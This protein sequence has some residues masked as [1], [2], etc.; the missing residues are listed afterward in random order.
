MIEISHVSKRFG[1]RLAVDDL[2]LSVNRGEIYGLLGH[3]GAGKSTTIGMMLG[4]VWP[5]SGELKLNSH[6]I[7]RHRAQALAWARFSRRPSSTIT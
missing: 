5:D 7:T 6:D 1:K 4:Q 3:N 2:S